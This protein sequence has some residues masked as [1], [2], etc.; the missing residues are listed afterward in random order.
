MAVYFA[1]D[2]LMRA[3]AMSLLVCLAWEGNLAAQSPNASGR[4]PHSA[5]A[6]RTNVPVDPFAGSA[7]STTAQPGASPAAPRS[8][9]SATG[10][11]SQA[12]LPRPYVTRQSD[13]EIPF[14]VRAGTTPATQPTAVRIFVSWDLGKSWHFY[15][16]RK[17]EEGR[18]RFRPKQD[19]EFWFATQTIDKSGR[20]DGAD[21]RRPQLRLIVDTQRPQLLVQAQVRQAGE[22]MVAWSAADASLVPASVKL[23]Y[24]DAVSD[25]APWQAAETSVTEPS[26]GT[27]TGQATFRP[28]V[29]GRTINLRA[30]IADA[31]GNAA[32]FSQKLSLAPTAPAQAAAG[33]GYRPPLDQT[34]THWPD[35]AGT[36]QPQHNHT[37]IATD[38]HTPAGASETA[39]ERVTIPNLVENP[40]AGKGRL[41]STSQ[42]VS[43]AATPAYGQRSS[44]PAHELSGAYGSDSRVEELP[45]PPASTAP[46]HSPGYGTSDEDA[47]WTP[48]GEASRETRATDDVGSGYASTPSPSGGYGSTPEEMPSPDRYGSE[49]PGPETMPAPEPTAPAYGSSSNYG[50]RAPDLAGSGES[51]ETPSGQRPRLTNSRRFSLDYDIDSVG[52][53]GVAAVELWGTGDGG[54]AWTKWGT[55]P[56]RTSP[57]DVEV[58]SEAVYGFRIVIVGKNGLATS[59]PQPGDAADIWV[60]IDATRPVARLTGAAYGQGEAAGKLEIRWEAA[61]ANLA[62]RPITLSIGDRP[63][64]PFSPIAAGLPNTGQY[65]WEFDPRSPRQIYLRLEARDDA[66]NI[67]IDQ[68][69]E[70]IKVEG[71]EPKGRIRGFNP[72]PEMRGAFKSPLFQ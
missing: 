41:A 69:T 66:G 6:Q 5:L 68:L 26:T 7:P 72:A 10:R 56:D 54:R 14:S 29:T 16:E 9:G 52:P 39:R 64:G 20:P 2:G 42:P 71:L 59:T 27:A 8:G 38:D 1:K 61:D 34:A 19:G 32:Y 23:E 47:S 44:Q 21:P 58:N 35:P 3:I 24:Q 53:E 46:R 43:S 55:D 63:D 60:G 51:V 31:A 17:P 62:A 48:A 45:L 28:A 25:S 70:P 49:T 33:G 37:M 57:F 11:A 22:V 18:F 30:E 4:V 13:M 40:F 67:T 65:F 50:T 15:E 36:T 12:E